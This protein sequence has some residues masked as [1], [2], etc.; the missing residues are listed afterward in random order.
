MRTAIDVINGAG[1]WAVDQGDNLPWLRGLPPR[2]VRTCVT[3]P[4]YYGL[5]N[6]SHDGQIG[7]EETPDD[8]VDAL[9]RVFRRVRNAL[10]DDGTL[11]L[12]LGDSYAGGAG[13]RGDIGNIIC[14]KSTR[15]TPVGVG[16]IPTNSGGLPAKNLMGMPWRVAF[17]LQADGWYLRQDI[18]WYKSN[19]MPESVTD[20]CTKAH[21]YLFLLAKSDK[22]YYDADAIRERA[23]STGG[24]ASFG[25]QNHD[26]A[27]TGQQSRTYERPDYEWKNKRSVW[28]IPTKS[29]HGAHFAVMPMAL[30]IPCIRAG[31]APGDVVMDPFAGSGTVL[32]AAVQER[33]RGIGAEL[34]PDYVTIARNRISGATPAL[35]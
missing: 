35:I 32:A 3:S 2:S 29:Y 20:R 7:L 4:P 19:P 5:R 13:G 18:I 9:V 16:R 31:S 23:V 27:G 14:G 1:T 11:W 15:T 22:Y 34:N 10:T 28:D 12:N 8:Y 33:R 6:Y 26:A 25:K 21:E 17:A 24:G 30:V